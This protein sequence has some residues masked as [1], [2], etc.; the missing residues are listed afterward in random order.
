MS[1]VRP[2]FHATAVEDPRCF[3]KNYEHPEMLSRC[4]ARF[5]HTTASSPMYREL[6][7]PAA[8]GRARAGPDPPGPPKRPR[9]A[10]DEDVA[11]G[12]LSRRREPGAVERKALPDNVADHVRDHVA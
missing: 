6:V 11:G 5:V 9:L 12:R 10:D 8:A 2:H 7:V 3:G 1:E 4:R